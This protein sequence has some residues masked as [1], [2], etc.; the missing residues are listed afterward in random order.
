MK[1]RN[2][3]LSPRTIRVIGLNEIRPANYFENYDRYGCDGCIIC[4]KPMKEGSDD[5][6]VHL[7]IVGDICEDS[8]EIKDQANGERDEIAQGWFQ[9]GKTCYKKFLR[10]AR[11]MSADEYID[12]AMTIL[13]R[14]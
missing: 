3:G 5:Y 4:G 7:T 6:W 9:V 14:K 13:R 11:V 8:G 12:K 2:E 10:S 1:T